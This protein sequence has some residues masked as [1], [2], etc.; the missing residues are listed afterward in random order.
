MSKEFKAT[1]AMIIALLTVAGAVYALATTSY[2][3]L[4]DKFLSHVS[5]Q[6]MEKVR[7]EH[8]LTAIEE[9]LKITNRLLNE[10]KEELKDVG[11]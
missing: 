2:N 7:E 6:Y 8:R 11:K 4:E 5:D 1:L 3:D 9:Q 10:S